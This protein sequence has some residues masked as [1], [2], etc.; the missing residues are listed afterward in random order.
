V[1]FSAGLIFGRRGDLHRLT[2]GVFLLSPPGVAILAGGR[3]QP[4]GGDFFDQ[5]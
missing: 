2:R 3:S 4:T 1:D 5:T